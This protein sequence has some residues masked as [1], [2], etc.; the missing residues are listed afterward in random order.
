MSAGKVRRKGAAGSCHPEKEGGEGPESRVA[1]S[2]RR[3]RKSSVGVSVCALSVSYRASL[4]PLIVSITVSR[5]NFLSLCICMS[6]PFRSIHQLFSRRQF[7]LPKCSTLAFRPQL[8][9]QTTAAWPYIYRQTPS[10]NMAPQLDAYFAKVDELQDH[11][12]ER[13]RKA[14]A[15]P[16]V[17]SED[18]RRPEVVRVCPRYAPLTAVTHADHTID[19]QVPRGRVEGTW[20]SRRGPPSWSPAPQRV[21]RAP[22]RHH[23]PLR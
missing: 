9:R 4:R 6:S 16:S 7:I 3:G 5:K 11:F 18:E 23:R 12:I 14:V 19:G 17:S 22:S 15:I 13:L 20:C 21:P 1:L 2:L 10:P 8:R